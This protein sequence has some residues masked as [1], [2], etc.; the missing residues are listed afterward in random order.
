LYKKFGII[1]NGPSPVTAKESSMADYFRF[2]QSKLLNLIST[3]SGNLVYDKTEKLA[4]SPAL[5]NVHVWNIRTGA[6][7]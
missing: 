7:V 5:E 1:L 4:V 6:L 3:A 2:E